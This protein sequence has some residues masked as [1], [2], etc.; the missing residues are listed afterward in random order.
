[1]ME[2]RFSMDSSSSRI[3]SLTLLPDAL[4]ASRLMGATTT[5]AIRLGARQTT[6]AT[7]TVARRLL[8]GRQENDTSRHV[9]LRTID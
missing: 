3:E 5:Q 7:H 4:S 6:Q 2:S 1:M 9:E 8:F